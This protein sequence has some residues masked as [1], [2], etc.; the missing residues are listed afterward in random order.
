[1]PAWQRTN[2]A[3]ILQE[4]EPQKTQA[5]AQHWIMCW[6][7]SLFRQVAVTG[8]AHICP[9]WAGRGNRGLRKGFWMLILHQPFC[10]PSEVKQVRKKLV[11][12]ALSDLWAGLSSHFLLSCY[13]TGT[14]IRAEL[15]SD[16]LVFSVPAPVQGT[17]TQG[18]AKTPVASHCDLGQPVYYTYICLSLYVHPE[19]KGTSFVP[20][21][22]PP[23]IP[24]FTSPCA[25]PRPTVWHSQERQPKISVIR[26]GLCPCCAVGP[27]QW[28]SCPPAGQ[29]G[30]IE[31]SCVS[32]ELCVCD[33]PEG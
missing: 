9:I 21:E 20:W 15:S 2:L 8:T 4:K 7:L 16:W 28:G 30:W 19:H 32:W 18:S 3:N 12:P 23:R 14:H 11:F 29:A 24:G 27:E 25:A 22:P 1:M 33:L 6:E 26:S 13:P 10:L 5:K 31:T 17:R